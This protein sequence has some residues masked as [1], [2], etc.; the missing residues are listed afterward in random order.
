MENP[1]IDAYLLEEQ[2][3]STKFHPDQISNDVALGFFEDGR[4]NNNKKNNKMSS[5]M[6]SVP[7]QKIAIWLKTDLCE[8]YSPHSLLIP[9]QSLLIS[10]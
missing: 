4:P 1:S 5:D 6:G 2:W 7:D 10:G 3:Y 9:L 8:N